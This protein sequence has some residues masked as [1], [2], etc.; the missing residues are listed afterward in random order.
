M[1]KSK[2]GFAGLWDEKAIDQITSTKEVWKYSSRVR[3]YRE[4]IR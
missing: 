2:R 1:N 4:F 3:L